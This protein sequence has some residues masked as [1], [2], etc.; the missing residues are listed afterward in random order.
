[1][2][3][4]EQ[5]AKVVTVAEM[6]AL[7]K[8]TDATGHSYATMME[9]AGRGV[10]QSIRARYAQV[11][12]VTVL[13]GPGNNGGDGLVCARYLHEAGQAVRVYLWRRRTAAAQD[14]EEHYAK[15]TA[16]GIPTAHADTDGDFT[17]L[18]AWLAE[19]ALLVD[20]LLG[21]G[22]NRPI[23]DQ[24]AAILAH[25]RA[26]QAQQA[27][28]VVAVD[29]VSG[30][31]SDTGA[32]DPAALPATLTITFAYP[33]WGHYQFP[34]V[35]VTGELQVID[36][37]IAPTLAAPIQTFLLTEALIRRWLPARP[38]NSHKGTYGKLLAAVG[39]VN[40]PGAA[41]LSCTAASRVGAGLVT[42]AVTKAVWSV[43]A[44][45]LAEATWLPLPT[46]NAAEEGV[47]S[48][49]AAAL[50]VASLAGYDVLLLGCGLG[51]K[52]TTQAFVQT[53]LAELPALE[54]LLIDADGL[55]CLAKL[56]TWP[57][58]LPTNTVLTPHAAELGRLCGL[59]VAEVV[60][61]RWQLAHQKAAEW[62]TVVLAKGPYTVIADPA[63]WLAILPLATAAL[64]TAGTGDVLSG[65]IAGLM[66]QG[67]DP[68]RAAC[69]GA[70]LHGTAGLRCAATMGT[71]GV[72]ASDLL[73][74]LPAII[75]E[76]RR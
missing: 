5:T 55:N 70:W 68:F 30:L 50:V 16:L 56:P 69:V 41:L 47:I 48:A 1:M 44:G 14:Y 2:Q 6:Q 24:L 3:A 43:V 38:N 20:A 13:V 71:T 57:T 45:R 73:A 60:A 18:C 59:P 36:I 19:T 39:S 65:T 49:D 4:I 33:K 62:G 28:P 63:G 72:M 64:A 10:A 46:G 53:L 8:A 15:V 74:H 75:H 27:Y 66:T 52:P 17:T 35:E 67:L 51:Q 61:Q 58:R 11:G 7:E 26:Y 29:C 40:Y 54:G 34:G 42:G 37:G 25:A 12:W 76:C 31:N 9:W 23:H 21:T 22:A 32:V